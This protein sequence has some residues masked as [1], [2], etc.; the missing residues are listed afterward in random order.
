MGKVRE[1]AR[2][3]GGKVPFAIRNERYELVPIDALT[4]HPK[5][6]RRG[7]V[8]AI[9]KSI[10]ANGFYGAVVAQ[11]GTNYILAGNHRWRAAKGEG[12]T[13]VP[14][15]WVDV[16]EKTARRIL[17][18]D[19]KTSDDA[20]YD[21]EALARV[22]EEVR[23]DADFAGTGYTDAD[24]DKLIAKVGDGVLE[25]GSELEGL[26]YRVVIECE[27]EAHQAELLGRLEG[28]GLKCRPLIS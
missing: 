28:E 6:P 21:E 16:D 5:N 1:S 24:L 26:E 9:A 2:R 17:L 27:S 22:L 19:N 15:L 13:E 7:D 4:P 18:A 11:T 23:S 14:V 20:T 25:A 10:A 3:E 8:G 12:A